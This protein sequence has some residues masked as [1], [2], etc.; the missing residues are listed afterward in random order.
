MVNKAF[1]LAE[2]LITLT[3]IGIIAALT[4][5][6]LITKYQKHSTLQ[7]FK[8]I[9]SVL[10]N[11]YQLSVRENGSPTEW[12]GFNTNPLPNGES[13]ESKVMASYFLPYLKIA[14]NCEASRGEC[15]ASKIYA[16]NKKDTSYMDM[17][18][19]YNVVLDDGTSL[20]FCD[21]SN[22]WTIMADLNGAKKGP[23]TLGNDIFLFALDYRKNGE[24]IP[25]NFFYYS[26]NGMVSTGNDAC[27]LNDRS[28]AGMCCSAL[29]VIDG[30]QMKND[31][32][33]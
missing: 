6:N 22:Y 26:R 27:S 20:A 2:T 19:K 30:L 13:S 17:C 1:S 3:I 8:K 32:P 31:Y 29:I 9:Y 28:T 21:N 10:M 15:F 25:Y 12:Y 33:W 18:A 16:K 24:F 4:M 23:N 7:Q 14:K 11:A 5:P